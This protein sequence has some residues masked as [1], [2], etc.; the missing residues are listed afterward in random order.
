MGRTVIEKFE[1]CAD[2]G[3]AV[4]L[5]TPDDP[6]TNGAMRA[7]QNVILELGYFIGKLGRARVCALKKGHMEIPSDIF[8][9]LFKQADAANEWRAEL[10]R[11]LQAA[12]Y[13]VGHFKQAVF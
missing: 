9:V 6:L 3:F 12:G 11:E 8:G 10:V 13:K 4:V 1:Q 5:L 7:R 2:V